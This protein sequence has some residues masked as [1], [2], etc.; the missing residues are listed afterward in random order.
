M[1]EVETRAAAKHATV[2]RAA[3]PTAM[4]YRAPHVL[5]RFAE[6]EKPWAGERSI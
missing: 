4:D 3:S 6:F 2:H 1:Q 5:Q